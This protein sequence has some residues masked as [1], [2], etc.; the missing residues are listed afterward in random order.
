RP[1]LVRSWRSQAS[2]SRIGRQRGP[3]LRVLLGQ[4]LQ[5]LLCRFPDD[6]ACRHIQRLGRSGQ[7]IG[8]FDRYLH[9]PYL[10]D[11][12]L[13]HRAP[14]FTQSVLTLYSS[15]KRK[16]SIIFGE[17]LNFLWKAIFFTVRWSMIPEIRF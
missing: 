11:L 14:T 15:V 1:S 12:R 7:P 3:D 13:F 5:L 6:P 16:S 9:V 17:G 8:P 10:S 2:L 4:L